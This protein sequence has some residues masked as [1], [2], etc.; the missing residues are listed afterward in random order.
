MNL[1]N[2]GFNAQR[3]IKQSDI[4]AFEG[5]FREFYSPLCHFSA[6][7]VNN[8]DTAEEIVQDFFYNYWKNREKIDIKVSV[9]SY[10][11]TSIRNQSLKHINQQEV[12]RRYVD[13]ITATSTETGKYNHLEEIQARELQQ[14]IDKT[15]DSLP[16][17]CRLVFSM[18]RLEGRKYQ[19]I[20]NELDISV[21]TVE[22]NIGKALH[23]LRISLENYQKEPLKRN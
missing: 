15:L 8:M 10:L 18:S 14:I 4:T 3:R 5:L 12:R 16:E 21:K 2:N 20:A 9:K 1:T 23:H 17:R 11:Y 22:A 13:L 7:F 6:G 19:E